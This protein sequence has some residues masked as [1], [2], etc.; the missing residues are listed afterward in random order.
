MASALAGKD[1]PAVADGAYHAGLALRVPVDVEG[2]A[3]GHPLEGGAAARPPQALQVAA[4]VGAGA[5]T[6]AE[7]ARQQVHGVVGERRGRVR[8]PAEPRAEG[9]R[10]VA[11]ALR[12]V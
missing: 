12:G 8:L 1:D 3:P 10:E 6:V 11:R 4:D 7:G 5:R 2:H 9:G